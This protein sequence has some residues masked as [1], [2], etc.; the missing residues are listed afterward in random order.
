MKAKGSNA[1]RELVARFWKEGFASIR[2]AGSG[3]SKFPCPDVIASNGTRIIAIEAKA[4]K[5]NIQYF[6][7]RQIT[8]LI[9]F[10]RVFGAEPYLAVKFSTIWYFFELQKLRQTRGGDY[11]VSKKDAKDLGVGFEEII[12]F[13]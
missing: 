7:E 1:E 6:R 9:E 13:H 5:Q 2:V 12:R 11:A 10:S 8:E 3:S 4:T